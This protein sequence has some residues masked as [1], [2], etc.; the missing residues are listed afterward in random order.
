MIK[1]MKIKVIK[2]SVGGCN[3]ETPW[4]MLSFILPMC[5]LSGQFLA[6][7]LDRVG[8]PLRLFGAVIWVMGFS[9]LYYQTNELIFDVS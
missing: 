6:E 7:L 1:G 4:L 8:S 3:S 2:L 9:S 5:I